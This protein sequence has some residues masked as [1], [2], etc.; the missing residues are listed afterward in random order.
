MSVTHHFQLALPLKKSGTYCRKRECLKRQ[1][2]LSNLIRSNAKKFA[3]RCTPSIKRRNA[4]ASNVNK[5]VNKHIHGRVDTLGRINAGGASINDCRGRPRK[6]TFALS[7]SKRRGSQHV[8]RARK[9]LPTCSQGGGKPNS[10]VDIK[11]YAETFRISNIP[12]RCTLST[13]GEVDCICKLYYKQT[14]VSN[15]KK[16]QLVNFHASNYER[17]L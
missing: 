6:K 8:V 4:H 15:S 9:P 14:R 12:L 7:R 10:Q 5:D 16:Q 17:V 2:V 1:Q 13:S 11:R 3:R